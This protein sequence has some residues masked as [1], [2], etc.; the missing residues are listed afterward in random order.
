MSTR[1]VPTLAMLLALATAACSTTAYQKQVGDFADGLTK[2]KSSFGDLATQEQQ[3]FVIEGTLT[4]IGPHSLIQIPD[5]CG[6]GPSGKIDCRPVIRNT[7]TDATVPVVNEPAAPQALK[8]AGAV[9]GYGKALVALAGADDVAKLKEAAGQATAALAQLAAD[10]GTPE[11][12][13]LGPTATFVSWL[14]G[15]YLDERRLEA[16]RDATNRATPL[17][18][19]SATLLAQLAGKLRDHVVSQRAALLQLEATALQRLRQ[20]HPTDR[21]AIFKA[22]SQLVA[23]G[24][25]VQQLADAD[26][27]APFNAMKASHAALAKALNDPSVSAADAFAQIQEFVNQVET[28]RS[29]L[30]ATATGGK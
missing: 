15:K 26:V 11:G 13:A 14:A 23:D 9:D 19:S 3:S 21:M 18:E 7:S 16:L 4:G 12:A 20:E 5:S 25:A 6:P 2:V 1:R 28:L 17:I 10:S 22:S 29:K 8:L 24:F 27:A 30:D